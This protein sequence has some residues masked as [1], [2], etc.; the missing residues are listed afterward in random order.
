MHEITAA[1]THEP[2]THTVESVTLK[3]PKPNEVLIDV[4]ATGVC[5]TDY[6]AYTSDRTEFPV[7]LGHEGAGVVDAVGSNVTTVDSGDH[8]VL[9]VLPSCGDC[10][11]CQRG[12]SYLCQARKDTRGRMMDGTRRL[13][14]S[15]T[16]V[17]HFY[18]QSSFA[19]MAV[20]PERQVVPVD[21][22][23][24]FEISALLGC[25][26]TT[27]L[28]AVTNIAEV[29]SG[30]TVAVFG[31]GGVG[32]GA[33]LAASAVSAGEIIAVDLDA[34]TLATMREIGATKTIDA[35]A[36]DPVTAIDDYVGSVDYAFEC[37][38]SPPTVTQSIEVIGPGGTAVITGT[39]DSDPIELD[40]GLFTSGI[41]VIGNIVGFTQPHVDIPKYVTMYQN[42]DLDLDA[43]LTDL[44]EIDELD[45]A[46]EALE[47]GEGIRSVVRFDPGP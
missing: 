43:I 30:E 1:V 6:H 39:S 28:G 29:E 5:H 10:Q 23:L 27:G 15:D 34:E 2:G 46:F 31:C 3:D 18:A 17:N 14:R 41:D 35:S 7:V 16:P 42:G 45:D 11:H 32:A 21:E 12:Q 19:S 37:I 33:I 24:P 38:G 36:T 22:T 4:R 47:S 26:V 9:W 13:S 40:L 20:V 8:V 44:Y 25:G